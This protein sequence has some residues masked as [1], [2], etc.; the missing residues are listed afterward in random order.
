M[1]FRS[2]IVT[3]RRMRGFAFNAWFGPVIVLGGWALSLATEH[4]GVTMWWSLVIVAALSWAATLKP[5]SAAGQPEGGE[6]QRWAYGPLGRSLATLMMLYHMAAVASPQMPEKDSWSTFRGPTND[7]FRTYLAT[8]QT[9]Q[10]WGMFAP[11]PPRSNVFMKVLVTDAAGETW[12]LRT[13]VNS[14]RNKQIPWIW[15]DRAGKITRRVIGEGKWYRSWLAR[16]HCRRWALD[17]DGEMPRTVELVRVWYEIPPPD[18]V[19]RLGYYRPAELLAREGHRSSLLT[20][21]CATE[22]DGQLTNE[23]RARHGLPQVDERT[24]RR[25]H[26]K[27][28]TGRFDPD[29]AD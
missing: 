29:A 2:L 19:A 20:V 11:N 1:L 24:I 21:T 4:Q 16:Y 25:R 5:A 9:S 12:D 13:D 26:P 15:Y 6:V 18:K 27:R 7:T 22:E 23:I 28:D 10:G 17:H 14:P 8:T 3:I